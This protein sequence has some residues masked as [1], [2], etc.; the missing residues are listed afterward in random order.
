MTKQ[1]AL[2]I[3]GGA[4]TILREMLT[5]TLEKQYKDALT[6]GLQK[7][8]DIL[9]RGGT[10]VE[11]VAAAVVV[12]EDCP[13]FNAGR[14][15][16]FSYEGK[17]ELEASIMCGKTLEAGA[18]ANVRTVK[19]PVLL[20]K[21]ILENP[22]FVYLSG[23]GADK[24]A[25]LNGLELVDQKYFY[26]EERYR[27]WQEVRDTNRAFL[28]H[29]V[30]IKNAEAKAGDYKFGTAGAVALDQYGNI[31]A[32]TS[33]GGLTNKKYGRLGDSSVI[34][35][36]TYANNNSCAVSCTGYGEFFLR[37][38]VA[39]DIAALVEYKGLSLKE[40]TN[41]V[42]K[43]KLVKMGGEGGIIAIDT[44][45]NIELCFNS[46][47]MYRGYVRSTDGKPNVFIYE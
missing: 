37:S 17:H 23:D 45:G 24:Y 25:A 16:V 2:A 14:G 9:K 22:D 36:G 4:G 43:D 7:G 10:A 33:T 29:N 15:A 44:Q 35:S 34:G 11:A 21:K 30:H 32:A 18:V 8:Q 19:N 6:L 39:Y 20:S 38:V 47:G 3:H 1:Y 13:L 28:D 41:K 12:A 31:A 27:Q 46:E 42:V 40:A 26:T 5:P